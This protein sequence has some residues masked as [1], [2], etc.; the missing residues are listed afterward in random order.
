MTSDKISEAYFV[1]FNDV[2]KL[3]WAY[4]SHYNLSDYER[5]AE[6]SNAEGSGLKFVSIQSSI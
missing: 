3:S 2:Q 1:S 6:S 5:T 4:C